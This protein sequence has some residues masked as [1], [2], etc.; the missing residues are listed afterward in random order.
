MIISPRLSI[1][2]KI[3][4]VDQKVSIDISL[5]KD[6]VRWKDISIYEGEQL[7]PEAEGKTALFDTCF[8]CHGFETR[9]ASVSR[10]ESGWRDRVNFMV[11]TMHITS[12]LVEDSLPIKNKEDVIS[13]LTSTFG[14]D[15][16]LP[17]SP[18]DIPKY[19]YVKLGPFRDE[20]LKIV[21]T[22]YELP[23]P[24]RMPWS[25]APDTNGNLWMPYF[26]DA[27]KIES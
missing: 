2:S 15:S 25:A 22:E 23:G 9:M 13:N 21:Y 7:L 12:S 10:D 4:A 19:Q 26:G 27:N 1:H 6:A 16:T 5:Q 20:A 8:A 17:K 11:T 3:L 24:N 18:A 14:P